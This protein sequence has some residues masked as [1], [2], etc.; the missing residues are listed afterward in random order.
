[1]DSNNRQTGK[2][3]TKPRALRL[4]GQW[5]LCPLRSIAAHRDHFVRRLSVRPSVCV[6]V[7]LCG[8]HTFFVVTHSYVLQ[9]THAFLGMLPLYFYSVRSFYLNHIAELLW[10]GECFLIFAPLLRKRGCTVSL[11]QN[12]MLVINHFSIAYN[13]ICSFKHWIAFCRCSRAIWIASE[14]RAN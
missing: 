2:D 5:F 14:R 10:Y 8:S 3:A 7:C 1:M 12:V 13:T 6:C 11:I 4:L 9:A